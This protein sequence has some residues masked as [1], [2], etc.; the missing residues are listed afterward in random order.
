MKLIGIYS[1]NFQPPH[2]GHFDAYKKLKQITGQNTYVITTDK[3]PIPTAPLNY[4]DKEQIL[5]RLGVSNTKKVK[6]LNDPKEILDNFSPEHTAVIYALNKKE[7]SKKIQNNYYR[8]FTGENVKDLLPFNQ[9]AYILIV[10]DNKIKDK[11][12]TTNNIREILGSPT[13]SEEQR[14]KL[15]RWIFGW[16]DLGL[17]ELLKEKFKHAYES[18]NNPESI[19]QKPEPLEPA[20]NIKEILKREIYKIL[21]E[22]MSPDSIPQGDTI[23]LTSATADDNSEV[24]KTE[25]RSQLA[26]DKQDLVKQKRDLERKGKMDKDQ[27]E[28]DKSSAELLRRSTIPDN[29]KSLDSINKQISQTRI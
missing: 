15:F 19:I 26:K 4:G 23:S 6:D 16:F 22:L 13:Y 10:D 18:D 21:S 11:V 29:R 14:K 3:N 5:T 20:A 27:L 28:R 8:E 25:M 2:R 1:G 12:I 17:Y 9:S 24:D 7:A